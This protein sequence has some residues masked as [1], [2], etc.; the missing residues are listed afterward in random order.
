MSARRQVVCLRPW[1]WISVVCRNF[2][3]KRRLTRSSWSLYR[4]HFEWCK[5]PCAS[6]MHTRD[7]FAVSTTSFNLHGKSSD[8]SDERESN[9]DQWSYDYFSMEIIV[10][11]AKRNDKSWWI[12]E[13]HWYSI[14]CVM[15]GSDDQWE[16]DDEAKR[17]KSYNSDNFS[18]WRQCKREWIYERSEE[19]IESSRFIKCRSIKNE[20][21]FVITWHFVKFDTRDDDVIS[22]IKTRIV[23]GLYD[24]LDHMS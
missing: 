17:D 20:H 2:C 21:L 13:N 1:Q 19:V 3:G 15:I 14:R 16:E 8:H 22:G 24:L 4:N 10:I 11:V 6:S 18:F 7:G 5:C 9:I 12:V 23:W